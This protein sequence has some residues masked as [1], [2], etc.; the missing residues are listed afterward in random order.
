MLT[1]FVEK[2]K[3]TKKRLILGK[4]LLRNFIV[5]STPQGLLVFVVKERRKCLGH[6]RG[7]R[8]S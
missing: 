2:K 1:E 8:D 6:S 7:I 3:I 5:L 4:N